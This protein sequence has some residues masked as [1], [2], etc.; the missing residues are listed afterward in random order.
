M[1]KLLK[2]VFVISLLFSVN[3]LKAQSSNNPD[4][5]ASFLKNSVQASVGYVVFYGSLDAYYERLLGSVN[6]TVPAVYYLRAG[7]GGINNYGNFDSYALI[8]LGLFTGFKTIHLEISGGAYYMFLQEEIKLSYSAGLRVQ[9]PGSHFM[10]RM[11]AGMPETI[12]LGF[13]FCF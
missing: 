12:Y 7:G 9:K 4:V 3:N 5:E 13:G 2:F 1:K 11:G 8:Q 10:F 6:N